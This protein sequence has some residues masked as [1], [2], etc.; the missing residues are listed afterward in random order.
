MGKLRKILNEIN[1]QLEAAAIAEMRIDKARE[2]LL[3]DETVGE[4][5]RVRRKFARPSMFSFDEE[6]LSMSVMTD[7]KLYSNS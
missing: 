4:G 3:N 6:S 7:K 2:T 5:T 1:K